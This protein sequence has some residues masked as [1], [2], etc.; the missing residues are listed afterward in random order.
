[1]NLKANK[2]AEI[3]GKVDF[4]Y[5]VQMNGD[6]YAIEVRK[7]G[8]TEALGGVSVS[9][10][11][12]PEVAAALEAGIGALAGYVARAMAKAVED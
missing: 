8:T 5:S 6:F 3:K 11:E 10:E 9:R 4:S 12:K 2:P 1:M 7:S